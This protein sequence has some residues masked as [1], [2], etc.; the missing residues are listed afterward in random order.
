MSHL[1]APAPSFQTV[2]RTFAQAPDLPARALLTVDQIQ[3][4]GA[5]L[6]VDFATEGHHV[7]TPALTLWTFL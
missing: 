5:D 2:L 7:W 4:A 6:G 3:A 1:Y